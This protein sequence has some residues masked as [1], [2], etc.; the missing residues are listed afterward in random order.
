MA[1]GYSTFGGTTRFLPTQTNYWYNASSQSTKAVYSS[2]FVAPDG[3]LANNGQR[4]VLVSQIGAYVSGLNLSRTCSFFLLG[5]D[6]PQSGASSQFTVPAAQSAG[7][8]GLKSLSSPQYFRT[9]SASSGLFE[10]A[11]GGNAFVGTIPGQG[12]S[13]YLL[14]GAPGSQTTVDQNASPKGLWAVVNYSQVPSSPSLSISSNGSYGFSASWSTPDWGDSS[15]G[16]GYELYIRQGANIV[17]A[18]TNISS[19]LNSLSIS[20]GLS[21]ST[22]YTAE[23]Y[24]KNELSGYAGSPKSV[25]GTGSF[26]TAAV[27]APTWSGSLGNGQVGVNYGTRTITASGATSVARTSGS[28]PPGLIESIGSNTYSL[29]GTP[30]G[31]GTYPLTIRARNAGG[32]S[33]TTQNINISPPTTPSWTDTTFKDGNAGQNYGSDS[34]TASNADYVTATPSSVAGLTVSVSGSTVTLSGTPS[35][36]ADGNY[37][38]SAIAYSVPNN[39]VRIQT[40]ATLSVTINGIPRP[41]WQDTTI[42]TLSA[43]NVPY[44]S[45]VSAT[46]TVNYS[47]VGSSPSW[48]S[49]NASTGALSGTPTSN[50][51]TYSLSEIDKQFTI[52]A[53]GS[54]GDSEDFTFSGIDVVHPIKMYKEATS[55]FDYPSQQVRRREGSSYANVQWV[56]R[57]NGSS[58]V[59]SD[60]N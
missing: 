33:F 43:I 5:S 44:S 42:E 59:D 35:S 23:I 11:I 10:I 36:S 13:P 45:S 53:T 58:W 18:N 57:W 27:P 9:G 14:L 6:S 19:S 3:R 17:Y 56:K 50:D 39:G 1:T 46:N 34:V 37:Q 26:T 2:L 47:F 12:V 24:A 48:L 49:L 21:P 16:R 55:S 41:T 38:I 8:T 20:S 29:Y 32:D 31:S 4:P 7:S 22:S 52:R 60:I 54:N 40:P 30:T 51:V 28:L 25:A 15:S